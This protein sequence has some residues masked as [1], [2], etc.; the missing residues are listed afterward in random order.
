MEL[1]GP[2]VEGKLEEM[3]LSEAGRE[4]YRHIEYRNVENSGCIYIYIYVFI[5]ILVIAVLRC[6]SHTIQLSHVR[7]F[8]G[9]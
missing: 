5:Y 1:L 4:E 2:S 9:F 3:S 7:F 8:S 6:N